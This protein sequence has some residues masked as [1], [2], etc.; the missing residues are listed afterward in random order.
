MKSQA[1]TGHR[2]WAE[3]RL[4]R[5][6]RRG[7]GGVGSSGRGGGGGAVAFHGGT[8][9]GRAPDLERGT[10][11][12][13]VRPPPSSSGLRASPFLFRSPRRGPS[14]DGVGRLRRSAP[15]SANPSPSLLTNSAAGARRRSYGGRCGGSSGG[16]GAGGSTSPL[17]DRPR[18]AADGGASRAASA[19]AAG[20]R[21]AP[22]C[23]WLRIDDELLR[24][25]GRFSSPPLP[26]PALLLCRPDPVRR[27]IRPRLPRAIHSLGRRAEEIGGVECDSATRRGRRHGRGKRPELGGDKASG[28]L[29]TT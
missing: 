12:S 3:R 16:A 27:L 6:S 15:S 29:H 17:L 28:P 7:S 22:P 13:G 25:A 9:A 2:G 21:R 10:A 4:K 18:R 19:P 5:R 14:G 20:R 24:A 26:S 8:G 11:T 1:E 23:G